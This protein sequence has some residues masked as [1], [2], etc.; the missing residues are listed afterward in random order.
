MRLAAQLVEK[1]LQLLVKLGGE[2]DDIRMVLAVVDRARDAIG[3]L[4]QALAPRMAIGW[5]WRGAELRGLAF[6]ILA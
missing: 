3:E 1:P 6:D 2:L 5:Q 4:A